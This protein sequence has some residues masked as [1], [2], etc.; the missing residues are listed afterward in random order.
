MS[1]APLGAPLKECEVKGA[2]ICLSL[3]KGKKAPA[4]RCFELKKSLEL[5][6]ELCSCSDR[7]R[8]TCL[9][10]S[11]GDESFCERAIYCVI[12]QTFL[13]ML[14]YLARPEKSTIFRNCVQLYFGER[15]L[16]EK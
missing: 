13:S 3:L 10:V 1:A 12:S 8:S 16:K 15:N 9:R 14:P 6:T 11:S 5:V 4:G 2:F 7:L